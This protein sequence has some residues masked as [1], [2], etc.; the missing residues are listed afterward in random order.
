MLIDVLQA[1]RR[2]N[3]H[4]QAGEQLAGDEIV[5]HVFT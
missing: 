4:P 3:V 1:L 2:A 5:R